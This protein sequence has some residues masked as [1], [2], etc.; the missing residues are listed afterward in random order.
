[1]R[2]TSV[3]L[4]NVLLP[5]LLHGGS[6]RAAEVTAAA[7]GEN[8]CF[9]GEPEAVATNGIGGVSDERNA[10]ALHV[11]DGHLLWQWGD[12][13]ELPA[14]APQTATVQQRRN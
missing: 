8:A 10:K 11:G 13:V 3:S 1:M 9:G 14:T 7:D 4:L 5:F 6:A 2:R 12:S